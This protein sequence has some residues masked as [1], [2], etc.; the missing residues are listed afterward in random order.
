MSAVTAREALDNCQPSVTLTLCKLGMLSQRCMLMSTRGCRFY[1]LFNFYFSL[2]SREKKERA[3]ES[4]RRRERERER[5]SSTRPHRGNCA[6][7]TLS[8]DVCRLTFKV[9][10]F[11]TVNYRCRT[12][13]GPSLPPLGRA[14]GQR[15]QGVRTLPRT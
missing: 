11:C 1:E 12:P 2:Q 14:A 9:A 6:S 7:I 8:R 10:L 3:R 15:L 4:E 5:T 13:A